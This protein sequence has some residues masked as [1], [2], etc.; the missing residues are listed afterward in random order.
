MATKGWGFGSPPSSVRFFLRSRASGLGFWCRLS[1][2]HEDMSRR[3][4]PAPENALEARRSVPDPIK[5]DAFAPTSTAS[6]DPKISTGVVGCRPAV[7]LHD[8]VQLLLLERSEKYD[9]SHMAAY[10]DGWSAALELLRRTELIL[11]SAPPDV[12]ALFAECVEQVRAAQYETL[13]DED[14]F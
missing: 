13:A 5:R 9:A 14:G 3:D 12:A 10:V 8:L 6:G 7:G 1:P 2:G 11:P 4:A